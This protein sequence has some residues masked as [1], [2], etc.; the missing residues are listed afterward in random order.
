MFESLKYLPDKECYLNIP[1]DMVDINPL[2]MENI[3]KHQDTDDALLKHAAKYADQ[4]MRKRI[5]AIDDILCCIKPG[6]PPNN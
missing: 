2:Y 1:D 4:Y 3:K 6:D 5:G